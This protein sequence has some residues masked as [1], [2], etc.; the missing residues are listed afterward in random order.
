MSVLGRDRTGAEVICRMILAL[1][2]RINIKT[3]DVMI[4]RP[5]PELSTFQKD[6]QLLDWRRWV[7]VVTIWTWV[8]WSEI[9]DLSTMRFKD[10]VNLT[11]WS[12]SFMIW[13]SL[14]IL[15]QS[16]DQFSVKLRSLCKRL[17]YNYGSWC[18]SKRKLLAKLLL[19]WEIEGLYWAFW[20]ITEKGEIALKSLNSR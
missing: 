8:L 13:Q 11:W 5:I 2:E 18:K 17:E 4:Y 15:F 10:F 20:D 19:P 3:W 12:H 14:D 7:N 6:T 1:S 9:W 16:V